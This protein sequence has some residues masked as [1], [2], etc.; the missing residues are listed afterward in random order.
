MVLVRPA[1][2]SSLVAALAM[3]GPLA[4]RDGTSL[5]LQAESGTEPSGSSSTTAMPE[6]TSAPEDGPPVCEPG[7]EPVLVSTWIHEG[8]A[9]D[10]VASAMARAQDGA[11]LVAV[12]RAAGGVR[13]VR[14][15]PDGTLAW[16]IAPQL[17]C[18][19]CVPTD[20]VIHPSGDLLLSATAVPTVEPP[21]AVLARVRADGSG[22][23]WTRELLLYEGSTTI[24]RAGRLAVHDDDRIVFVQLE[25]FSTSELLVLRELGADGTTRVRRNLLA[26]TGSM[27]GWPLLVAAG[28]QG[29]VVLA[30]PWWNEEDDPEAPRLQG[31]T[32]RHL[33]PT[34]E[35]IS[36]IPLAL[37]LDELAIDSIG[38]R[39][40][41]ARS[42][43]AET[44]TL[45]LSS[46]SA[47]DP[48]G[49]SRSLPLVTTSSTRPALAIGSGDEVYVAA[50]TTPRAVDDRYF[51]VELAAARW[52]AQ[53]ELQWQASTPLDM[54]ATDDPL[55]LVVDDDDGLVIATVVQGSLRVIRYEQAC[56]CE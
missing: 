36:S 54:V 11:L 39:L 4:C 15:E 24:S 17:P 26:Q 2:V 31:L 32:S 19:A 27:S 47:S 21:A 25:G 33:P 7:C 22:L 5:D 13:L 9:G 56:A 44:S 34:Y 41:L 10:Q 52:S 55:E 42:A 28:P 12:R 37:A 49:W 8:E 48:E 50:R 53:G 14:L 43:D 1:L 51:V 38:R 29:D 35:A 23:V 18:G 16:S 6:D 46:R 40:E 45:L 3:L 30:Y 20:L